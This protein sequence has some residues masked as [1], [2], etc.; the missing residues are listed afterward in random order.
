MKKFYF[1]FILSLLIVFSCTHVAQ[2]PTR[3]L[4]P[5]KR[6]TAGNGAERGCGDALYC[7][8]GPFGKK[9][10]LSDT[11]A[12]FNSD[13]KEAFERIEKLVPKRHLSAFVA[14]LTSLGIREEYRENF[15]KIVLAQMYYFKIIEEPGPLEEI[16]DDNIELPEG[17]TEKI[18]L[19]IHHIDDFEIHVNKTVYAD[20]TDVEKEFLLIHEAFIWSYYMLN[21]V[22]IF[23][24]ESRPTWDN[25]LNPNAKYDTTQIRNFLKKLA[26][27]PQFAAWYDGF[28][29]FV[30][31]PGMR[32]YALLLDLK[33]S[34]WINPKKEYK[35]S[36]AKGI[37]DPDVRDFSKSLQ[38]QIM[39]APRIWMV[40]E[41]SNFEVGW[42][43]TFAVTVNAVIVDVRPV[44]FVT[45][46]PGVLKPNQIKNLGIMEFSCRRPL[47][48]ADFDMPSIGRQRRN[49]T[50][51][52]SPV[53]YSPC[54]IEKLL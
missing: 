54:Q 46:T 1:L 7:P 43:Q 37:S 19:A 41:E 14:E 20:L 13:K 50:M 53:E 39:K 32:A 48:S 38:F 52:K 5:A 26:D 9:Y 28:K 34:Q 51:D 35:M 17:C 23:D 44:N 3:T 42:V 16:D 4:T 22:N 21:R 30:S 31:V 25:Y 49:T 8:K 2:P 36:L 27:G 18:Q 45:N 33:F 12:L 47:N 29:T 40:S 6:T 24:P 11:Y 10:Y 15:I